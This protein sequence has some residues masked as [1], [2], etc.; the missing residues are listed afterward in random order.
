MLFVR[1]VAVFRFFSHHH[2]FLQADRLCNVPES[3]AYRWDK[4]DLSENST[5]VYCCS[6]YSVG[7]SS[8]LDMINT[9][10]ENVKTLLALLYTFI[11]MLGFIFT[12]KYQSSAYFKFRHNCSNMGSGQLSCSIAKI[13]GGGCL[14][15]I[16]ILW[17]CQLWFY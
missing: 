8:I 7:S 11:L 4:K 10:R 9:Y 1:K 15:I 12:I 17:R 13:Q 5:T 2:P 6:P 14:A 3:V 16:R